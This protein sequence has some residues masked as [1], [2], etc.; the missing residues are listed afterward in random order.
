MEFSYDTLKNDLLYRTRGVTFSMVIEAIAEKGILLT[1]DHPNQLKYP[2]EKVLVIELDGYAHCVP[3]VIEGE[4]WCL[5]T[6]YPDR[7]F[8]YLI[9]G[10]PHG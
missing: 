3:Y 1:F 4:I 8:K 9:E 5:K 2:N 10:E 7:R 6:I